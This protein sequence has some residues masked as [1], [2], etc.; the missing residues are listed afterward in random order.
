MD[1]ILVLENDNGV[2]ND[3][4]KHSKKEK[5]A[6]LEHTELFSLVGEHA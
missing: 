2:K 3:I 6:V 4:N 1:S 5:E